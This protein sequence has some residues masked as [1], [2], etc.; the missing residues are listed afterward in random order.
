KKD[1]K[2]IEKIVYEY[3]SNEIK[4]KIYTLD[5]EEWKISRIFHLEKINGKLYLKKDEYKSNNIEEWD[6]NTYEPYREWYYYSV[7]GRIYKENAP[8]EEKYNEKGQ[9]IEK[10]YENDFIKKKEQFTYNNSGDIEILELYDGKDEKGEFIRWEKRVYT[11]DPNIL[12]EEVVDKWQ[13]NDKNRTPH[14]A[15]LLKEVYRPTDDGGYEL[16]YK[17]QYY[18]SPIP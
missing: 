14:N 18:Y 7:E 8:T 17:Q 6:V 10:I 11:Y 1:W 16:L 2:E 5:E 9:V 3:S 4:K 12:N 15:I 13:E